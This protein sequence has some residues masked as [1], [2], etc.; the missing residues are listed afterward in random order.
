MTELSLESTQNINRNA[1]SKGETYVENGVTTSQIRQIYSEIKRAENE[2]QHEEKKKAK[3]TLVLLKPKIAYLAAKSD[4]NGME[5]VNDDFSGWIDKAVN[6]DERNIE[7]FF[8]FSEAIVA[9]H[10]YFDEGGDR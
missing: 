2:Y 1:K 8:Q 10:E 9:Y 7:F 4:E 5:M 3:Q 6:N